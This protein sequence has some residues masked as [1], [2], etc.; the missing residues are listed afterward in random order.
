MISFSI[1]VDNNKAIWNQEK[2]YVFT[3]DKNTQKK[4]D[5]QSKLDEQYNI[6]ILLTVDVV[7]LLTILGIETRTL[8]MLDMH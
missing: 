1:G 6:V 4:Q 8:C 7:S 3:D 2:Y 5:L